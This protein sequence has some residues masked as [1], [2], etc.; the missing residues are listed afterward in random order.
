M[1]QGDCGA[2]L[3]RRWSYPSRR[4]GRSEQMVEEADGENETLLCEREI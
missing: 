4:K 2:T 1:L 3:E